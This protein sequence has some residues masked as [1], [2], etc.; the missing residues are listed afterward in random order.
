[1]MYLNQVSPPSLKDVT[2][3]GDVLGMR[4]SVTVAKVQ[5]LSHMGLPRGQAL[6]NS[7]CPREGALLGCG[8]GLTERERESAKKEMFLGEIRCR[9]ATRLHLRSLTFHSTHRAPASQ[10]GLLCSLHQPQCGDPMYIA[11]WQ[12]DCVGRRGWGPDSCLAFL[13]HCIT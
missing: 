6:L 1:M 8:V 12:S 7:P 4:C 5:L 2:S 11:G 3:L 13:Q 9:T 10:E